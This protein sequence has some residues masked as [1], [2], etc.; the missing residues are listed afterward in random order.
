MR[1]NILQQRLGVRR[2]GASSVVRRSFHTSRF[3]QRREIIQ[4]SNMHRS[5]RACCIEY[6]HRVH[7]VRVTQ[8][9]RL[10]RYDYVGRSFTNYRHH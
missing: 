10:I 8:R 2:E 5:N 6:L 3:I 9:H 4:L 1:T 7:K